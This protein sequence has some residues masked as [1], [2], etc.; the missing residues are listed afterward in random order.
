MQSAQRDEDAFATVGVGQC[1]GAP[2]VRD[3][4]LDDDEVWAVVVSTRSTCS[5]TI[6]GLVVV[7]QVGSERGEAERRK[8]RVLDRTPERTGRFSQRRQDEL[9]A[10]ASLSHHSKFFVSQSIAAPKPLLV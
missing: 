8:Q 6:D 7:T 2:R 10:K 1:V 9:H 4:D 3:V 5:S